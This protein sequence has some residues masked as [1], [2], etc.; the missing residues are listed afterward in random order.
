MKPPILAN[1]IISELRH[2]YHKLPGAITPANDRVYGEQYMDDNIPASLESTTLGLPGYTVAHGGQNRA[3]SSYRNQV[4][5][6][7]LLHLI[8]I[9]IY[10]TLFGVYSKHY[11]HRIVIQLDESWVPTIMTT[12]SQLTGTVCQAIE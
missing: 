10:I 12:T 9:F 6:T 4:A 1:D 8:L 2:E 7:M 11:E 5:V 3:E